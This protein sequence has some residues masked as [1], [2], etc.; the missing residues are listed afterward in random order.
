MVDVGFLRFFCLPC[1]RGWDVAVA[2]FDPNSDTTNIDTYTSIP[3]VTND[4]CMVLYFQD[5]H[6]TVLRLPSRFNSVR[7]FVREVGEDEKI[8]VI[9]HTIRAWYGD[10]NEG[11]RTPD[12]RTS[13]QNAPQVKPEPNCTSKLEPHIKAELA[14]DHRWRLA[15]KKGGDS[16][17]SSQAPPISLISES[18]SDTE[19]DAGQEP[20][21]TAT[22]P[23]HDH[24]DLLDAAGP[25]SHNDKIKYMDHLRQQQ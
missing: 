14:S 9:N 6:F 12:R 13:N 19:P 16:A 7:D 2:S 23:K 15:Q 18:K 11:F 17:E 22:E 8:F 5:E 10:E 21:A 1:L 24:H 4:K 3:D 25:T 20:G